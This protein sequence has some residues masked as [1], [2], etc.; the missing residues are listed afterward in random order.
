MHENKKSRDNQLNDHFSSQSLMH[1]NAFNQ[2]KN[3]FSEYEGG[4]ETKMQ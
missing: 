1:A 3:P 2:I 4:N